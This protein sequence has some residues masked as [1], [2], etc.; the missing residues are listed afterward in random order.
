MHGN[1]IIGG[2]IDL[3][4]LAAR[5][6]QNATAPAGGLSTEAQTPQAAQTGAGVSAAPQQSVQ[7]ENVVFEVTQANLQQTIELSHIVPVLLLVYTAESEKLQPQLADL[8]S[9]VRGEQGKLALGLIAAEQQ[10]E[11]VA[12]LQ[13]QA[14]PAVLFVLA[15]RPEMLYQ[16]SQPLATLKQVTAQ[17]VALAAE[18][19]FT[20]SVTGAD[21]ADAAHTAEPAEPAIP[22]AHT[23]AHA[24]AEAGDFAL[25]AAEYQKVLA[26]SP[27]DDLAREALA[28]VQLLA[29]LAGKTQEEIRQAAAADPLNVAAQMQVADLDVAGGHVTDAFARLL[30]L[31]PHVDAA[32]QEQLRTRLLELFLVVGV[33]DERVGAAR[34]KLASLIY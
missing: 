5:A 7:L 11:L 26:T 24:A 16:G 12:A 31:Y 23:A 28:Q 2:G 20:G 34:R 14:A 9:C 17:L 18:Q 6:Q 21:L 15:G 19:G 32:A 4:H 27:G 29:R 30:D 33:T 1:R 3:S 8:A 22:P 25:A 13:L 10:P